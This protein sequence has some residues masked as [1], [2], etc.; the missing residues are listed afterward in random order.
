[1][2]ITTTID[3][4]LPGDPPEVFDAKAFA[5]WAALAGLGAEINASSAEMTTKVNQ[6]AGSAT[7]AANSANAADAS[8]TA[9]DA[10]K[11][12]AAASASTATTKASEADASKTAAAASA[13]TASNA[14]TAADASKTA[15]A[16]SAT[17]ATTKA[18]EAAASATT[19]SGAATTA[20]T[21]A[22]EASNSA[23]TASA[24]AT[25]ATTKAGEASASATTASNAATTATTKASEASNSATTATTK[26]GEA[27]ASASAAEQ[28]KL[29][30]Q[31]AAQQAAGGG[32]PTIIAGTTG[33]YW[34][35]D[36]TWRDFFAD[37]RAATLASLSTASNAAISATDSVLAALG[38]L[39]AQITGHVGTGGGAHA[40]ATTTASG[41]MSGADK[42]K[43]NGIA[44]NA[45]ANATDAQLRDRATHTGSQAISTITGLQT[46]LDGKAADSAALT[47][48]AG[49][50][51][52]PA[53]TAEPV[54]S[55][56]QVLRNN[57]KQAFAD[58]AGKA[59]DSDVVKLTGAQTVAGGKTFSN[60]SSH[61]GAYTPSLT[62]AHSATP[63]FDCAAGNVFEP[64]AMTG[65]V[66]SITL[67]NAVAGQTV[68]I[69]F[70]QDATGGR[71]CAVPSGAK[72]DGSINTAANRV[73]WLILTYSSR[74][75][76]WE[77]NWLQVP[78]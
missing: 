29:D 68:Q 2:P 57:I 5:A 12:A 16:G 47:D 26:A 42:T 32:E 34:H 63:T 43:L 19:A 49:T 27:S 71:T 15:A 11:N 72:V 46:A 6:A 70:Q 60:R 22:G 8:K 3:P 36:K 45:T 33:Q 76:R 62:P 37:V 53:T 66:T 64:A 67:S 30:A 17:T 20:T 74:G 41:F 75:S 50:A 40:D 1:M 44:T 69:R 61:A 18:G 78:A 51:T 38:K 65:N 14:A 77:G 23:T 52:L 9:A 7:A 56:L 25:T 24:A 31:A 48:A 58:L 35:G 28:A 55:R 4:P 13:T 39:Q 59:A 10:S 21:K 54:A 73:S